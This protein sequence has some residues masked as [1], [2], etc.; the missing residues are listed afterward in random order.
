[1]TRQFVQTNVRLAFAVSNA[2]YHPVE[3]TGKSANVPSLISPY[4]TAS[5]INCTECHNNSSGRQAG[6]AG[7]MGPHGSA[8]VPL[9]ERRQELTD[10]Q[11][12][13]SAIYALCYKCH[14]RASILGSETF[15]R[16]RHAYHRAENRLHHLP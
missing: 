15:Q 13:S 4:T 2:S 14:S 11:M 5:R 1:M 12:E 8:Y 6:G 10:F 3:A 7:P 16:P 9:L